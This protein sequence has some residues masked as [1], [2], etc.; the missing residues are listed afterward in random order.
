MSVALCSDMVQTIPLTNANS[1]VIVTV[2][3]NPA[4]LASVIA[5][6]GD[7]RTIGNF[8]NAAFGGHYTTN[9]SY[10][11][12][13]TLITNMRASVSTYRITSQSVTCELIAPALSDQGTITASQFKMSPRTGSLCRAADNNVTA[14]LY[15]D[16]AVYQAPGVE[17]AMVLG[18]MAYTSKARDGVYLP[19]KLSNFKWR[20]M[21]DNVAYFETEGASFGEYPERLNCASSLVFPYSEHREDGHFWELVGA[22]MCGNNFGKIVIGG[23]AANV[24]IRIRVRQVLEITALPGTT[25]APLLEAALPPDE[26]SLRMYFEVSARMADAYPASYNDLGKLWNVI[27][28]IGQKVLPYVEPALDFISKSGIPVASTVATVA[29]S[30]VPAVKTAVT[31]IKAAKAKK[32]KTLPAAKK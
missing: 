31:A 4:V 29:K 18:T 12:T 7:F 16:I 11:N 2:P 24:A 23:L 28:G 25:Y 6:D 15:P 3:P 30:A 1:S 10:D 20:S 17:S 13:R 5:Y 9:P 27:K 32:K 26:T 19:L 14:D 21:T 8:Y 22:K